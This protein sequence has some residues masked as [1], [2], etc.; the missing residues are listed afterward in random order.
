MPFDGRII[1]PV[2]SLELRKPVQLVPDGT[3]CAWTPLSPEKAVKQWPKRQHRAWRLH[4]LSS[5]FRRR[6]PWPERASRVTVAHAVTLASDQAWGMQQDVHELSPDL[7]GGHAPCFN[8]GHILRLRKS[9]T[10]TF[11]SRRCGASGHDLCMLTVVSA[12]DA[13]IAQWQRSKKR[14]KQG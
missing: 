4:P 10:G 7:F 2:S 12:P 5:F 6:L 8:F 11:V 3:E 14:R 9:A 13:A 1:V